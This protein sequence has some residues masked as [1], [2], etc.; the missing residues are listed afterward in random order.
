MSADRPSENPPPA[1]AEDGSRGRSPSSASA[2]FP[3]R[4]GEPPASRGAGIRPGARL[5]SL[6]GR[7]GVLWWYSLLM[8]VCARAG[9][10]VNFY[11]TMFLLPAYVS[12]ERLGLV[13]PLL[14]L[15]AFVAVPQAILIRTALK[16]V[17]VFEVAGEK[18]KTKALLRDLLLLSALFSAGLAVYLWSLRDF[19]GLRL[20]VEGTAAIWLVIGLSIVLYGW[21]PVVRMLAQG[22]KRFYSLIVSGLL[23]PVVRLGLVLLLL[24]RFQVVGYLASILL[25]TV[26]VML[27]LL[28]G[29]RRTFS[30]AVRA[31]SYRAHWREMGRFLAPCAVLTAVLG[32]Q[33]AAEPWIIRQRLPELD[34]AGYFVV[35]S[36]GNVSLFALSAV[37]PFLFPLVAERHERGESTR[38]MH[39]QVVGLSLAVTVALAILFAL[40]GPLILRLHPAWRPYAG[41]APFLWQFAIVAGIGALVDSHTTYESA[42]GRFKFLWYVAPV[43]LLEI[44]VLQAFMGWTFFQPFLPAGLWG[45]VNGWVR[46]DL[47]FIVGCMLLA[48]LVLIAGVAGETWVGVRRERRERRFHPAATPG[49]VFASP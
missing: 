19:I 32:L 43:V 29:A 49:G 37:M 9:D 14:Q 10:L 1:R 36:L 35:A 27:F 11:V 33:L 23:Y 45:A 47:Q 12:K 48:R 46:R 42:C 25:A 2:G 40:A 22:L 39:L 20:R 7:L 31:E 3:Q 24:A 6:Q 28:W 13:M 41:Y 26:V 30:A 34:S 17:N 8:F 4:E 21:M 18:G 15:A 16:Y 44:V 5:K 38:R